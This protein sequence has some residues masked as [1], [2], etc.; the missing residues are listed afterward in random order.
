MSFPSFLIN[1]ALACRARL[2]PPALTLIPV[3]GVTGTA[4]ALLIGI[5]GLASIEML[6]VTLT[7]LRAGDRLSAGTLN[8]DG[9]WTLLGD[10][11]A[12]LMLMVGEGGTVVLGV[13]ATVFDAASETVT[14]ASGTVRAEI[15]ASVLRETVFETVH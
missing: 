10:D 11:L 1:D 4:V 3:F 8:S 7:G 12:G 5:D 13:M 6:I 2:D 9:S 15:S 14:M